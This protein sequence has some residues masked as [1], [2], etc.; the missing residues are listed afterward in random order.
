MLQSLGS[1]YRSVIDDLVKSC[2]EGQGQIGARRV[3]AGIWNANADDPSK[4]LPDQH[5][6]N[7]MLR[8]LSLDDRPVLAQMLT[9]AFVGGVHETLV[10]LHQHAVPP[11][12]DGYQGTRFNDFSGRLVGWEWPGQ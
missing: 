7:D 9:N 10:V 1:G 6:M 2:R 8:R 11:F 5:A 12:D 3:K 4:D